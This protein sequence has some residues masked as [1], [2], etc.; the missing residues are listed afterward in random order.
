MLQRLKTN[1]KSKTK[2][3]VTFDLKKNYYADNHDK[4]CVVCVCV[5]SG[6]GHLV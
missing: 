5:F 3:N 4:R 6:V 1:T 2:Q